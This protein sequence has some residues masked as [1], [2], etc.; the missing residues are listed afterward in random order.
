MERSLEVLSSQCDL[1][2]LGITPGKIKCAK[3]LRR[4][5]GHIVY[6]IACERGYYVLKWFN[7]PD[8]SIELR[9]YALLERCGVPTLPVYGCSTQALLL[10]DLDHSSVWRL[11]CESDMG[12]ST[13]GVAIAEWYHNL[14]KA[15]REVL[16][17]PELRPRF[18]QAWVD[19]ISGRSLNAAGMSL[20]VEDDPAW[21]LAVEHVEQLKSAFRALP[22]TFNYNDFALEN[23]ALSHSGR[24]TLRAVVF[25]YDQFSIGPA[26]SDWRNVMSAL[27]GAARAAFEETYGIVS[28]EEQ[29]L[30]NP[31]SVLYGLIV[32]SRRN[33]LPGWAIS[34]LEMVRNG[35]L[36]RRICRALEFTR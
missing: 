14:H 17:N 12:W 7:G 10:E 4:R 27:R 31:L 2:P 9:V 33:R 23:L 22:Q 19:E 15:G 1:A 25:D 26:Y 13:T 8:R 20:G 11:A 30:D 3:V 6:R 32:A 36:E 21:V 29:I 35:E 16:E 34:P 28:E 5:A 18:L 24:E